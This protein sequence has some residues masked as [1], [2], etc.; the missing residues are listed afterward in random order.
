MHLHLLLG[1]ER[2]KLEKIDLRRKLI[3]EKNRIR[4]ED[5]S[6][7]VFD[8]S[9]KGFPQCTGSTTMGNRGNLLPTKTSRERDTTADQ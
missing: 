2:R 5:K 6:W 4:A 9:S 7:F 8:S 3:R 1:F